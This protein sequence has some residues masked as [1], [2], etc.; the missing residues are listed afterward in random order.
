MQYLGHP[1]GLCVNL[2]ISRIFRKFYCIRFLLY[3]QLHCIC[4]HKC[5][6]S[7]SV[8]FSLLILNYKLIDVYDGDIAAEQD[9]KNQVMTTN[10]WLEQVC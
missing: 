2:N 4:K 8:S 3:L 7:I 6:G 5:L 9:E 10:V 1:V